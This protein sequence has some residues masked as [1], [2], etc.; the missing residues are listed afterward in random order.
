MKRSIVRL[1][2]HESYYDGLSF[3]RDRR[4][5]F[6][7]LA[8]PV[9]FLVIFG[10]VFGHS[11]VPVSGG[12]VSTAVYY[13]PSLIA[14][15][16]VAAAFVNL[17]LTVT[18]SR[19]SGIYKRRRATP[20]PAAVIIGGRALVAIVTA[21]AITVI[22]VA[23]G[24][25]AYGATLSLTQV[26]ALLIA[27]VAGALTFCCLGF[28]VSTFI[29]DQDSVQPITQAIMLPLYFISGV[30]V[31]VALL[32]E[33]MT[34]IANFFPVRHLVVATLTAYN[35]Y[36]SGAGFAWHDLS[37]LALWCAIGLVIALRRFTWLP[38]KG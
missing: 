23:I 32:P 11:L 28:A 3:A 4:A 13:V 18:V 1:L 2:G 14:F 25:P 36:A 38:L 20:V 15:G 5:L 9:I 21:L 10:A 6:F 26:P 17:V 33:W 12:K 35:P 7:T 16:V 22:L 37:I 30:F 19:E 31:P 34:R 24:W 29:R 27:V 8:L